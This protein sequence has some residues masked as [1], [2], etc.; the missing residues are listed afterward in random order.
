[1]RSPVDYFR[2][3]FAFVVPLLLVASALA[4][5]FLPNAIWPTRSFA[6]LLASTVGFYT[7]FIAIK[8][9]F[10]PQQRSIF[11]RQGLIPRKQPELA[12]RLGSGISEHFFNAAEIQQ[13][14]E[15]Q[16]LL[17]KTA[18]RLK[19]QLDQ[20]LADEKIQLQLSNWLAQKVN[21]HTDEINY[22]LVRL[23]DKNLTKIL[24]QETDL[25]K[26]AQ[27]LSQYI[28]QRIA[29]GDIDLEE[30]VDKVAELAA[31]NIPEFAVWLHQQFEEYNE[32]QGVIA[33]NMMGFLKWAS[34]ID[35]VA[36]AEQLY[37]MI[38]THEFRSG[39]YQLSERMVLSLTEYLATEEGAE[40]LDHIND[41][42]NHYLIETAREQ[43]I[44]ALI[45]RTEAWLKSPAAWQSIDSIV[46]RI[47]DKIEHEMNLY[48]HSDKFKSN[49]EIWI[50]D[51]LKRFNVEQ[52]I[53][54]KVRQLDTGKLEKL[55]LSATGEHLAAIE[56][57]GGVL[58]AFAGIALFSLPIFFVL[59]GLLLAALWIENYLGSRSD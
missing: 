31:E 19:E 51:L 24:A 55:V 20:S 14:L 18:Q 57:L 22:F 25:V 12:T 39:V 27:Q 29:A 15:E 49:L 8:M 21:S 17:Q 30:I 7:N 56:I 58:G 46:I 5:H 2:F 59:L 48:L 43:G 50:P 36:L 53:A 44:P 26:L 33:R 9:L 37:R 10:R 1:M 11:G 6:I 52:F 13:Y 34:D 38:S 45:Q 32:S 4:Q 16:Q 28:E 47:V 23:S 41:K 3:F 54:R 40:F 42:L 35:E